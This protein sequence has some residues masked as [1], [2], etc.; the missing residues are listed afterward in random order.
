[1]HTCVDLYM[2]QEEKRVLEK[3]VEGWRSVDKEEREKGELVAAEKRARAQVDE[4]RRR[5]EE[6]RKDYE[7]RKE[8]LKEEAVRK[9]R[10]L[11]EDNRHLQR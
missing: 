11:T 9:N 3:E 6:M 1:M 5:F 8:H 10:S 2:P 7:K 4:M